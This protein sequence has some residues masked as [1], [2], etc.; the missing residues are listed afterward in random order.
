MYTTGAGEAYLARLVTAAENN[1][2][3]ARGLKESLLQD[4]SGLMHALNDRQ[5]AAQQEQNQMM[6]VQIS[7]A[8]RD[9]LAEPMRLLS[10]IVQE[11]TRDQRTAVGTLIEGV[12]AGFMDKLGDTFGE[13]IQGITQSIQQSSEAVGKVQDVMTKSITDI[14]QAGMTA[15]DRMSDKVEDALSRLAATQEMVSQQMADYQKQSS[16]VME[17]TV[18]AV[19]AKLQAAVTNLS[20]E[21]SQ[22]MAQDQQRHDNLLSS[23]QALYAGL[24]ENVGGLVEDIRLSTRK[25]EENLSVLQRTVT[26]AISGMNEGAVVVQAAADKFAVAGHS[27]SGLTDTMAQTASSLQQTAGLVRQSFDE[28][29]RTRETAQQYVAQMQALVET[30]SAESGISQKLIDDMERIVGSFATAERQS[31]EY[32]SR[33]NEILKQSFHDFGIEMVAQVRNINAESNRQL[34]TSLHAL[35]GTVD[36]MIASVTKLRRAG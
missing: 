15:A 12:Q 7:E 30:L 27:I 21:R 22:Q 36:S 13:Q 9:A 1:P 28:Y 31:A 32:L 25:T 18:R 26:H 33:I 16:E 20:T 2:A 19:L 3:D 5:I 23:T 10:G 35:S 8:I 29:D 11:V 6:S 14:S 4:L 24:S 17:V 34:G